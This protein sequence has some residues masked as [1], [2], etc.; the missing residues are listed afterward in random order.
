MTFN[1]EKNLKEKA[2]T[3]AQKYLCR[4]KQEHTP[5]DPIFFPYAEFNEAAAKLNIPLNEFETEV[6]GYYL[7][8]EPE[9]EISFIVV[10]NTIVDEL[11]WLY[12]RDL[13]TC[14]VVV[15]PKDNTNR[16]FCWWCKG[17]TQTKQLCTTLY[18]YCTRC[19][20]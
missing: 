3:L 4:V 8:G 18:K 5:Q 15:E 11:C 10:L 17:A 14:D 12:S 13:K 19:K 7:E 20:K 16:D 2:C 6:C 1:E 9:I